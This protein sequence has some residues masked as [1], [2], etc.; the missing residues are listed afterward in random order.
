MWNATQD[1]PVGNEKGGLG[2]GS[3]TLHGSCGATIISLRHAVQT[4]LE[5]AM[6]MHQ[7]HANRS[8]KVQAC[9]SR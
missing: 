9:G 7:S 4:L 2:V 8:S 6:A 1:D 3:P 5:E